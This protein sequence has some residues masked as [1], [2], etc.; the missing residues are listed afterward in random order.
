[1]EPEIIIS[2]LKDLLPK[3]NRDHGGSLISHYINSI[4]QSLESIE[5]NSTHNFF[6]SIYHV[7][8]I[9]ILNEYS[10]IDLMLLF[11]IQT[12]TSDQLP[13]HLRSEYFQHSKYFSFSHLFSEIKL[14]DE[15]YSETNLNDRPA[16][17]CLSN[18]I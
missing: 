14:L 11:L 15:F 12:K 5:N 8:S 4:H 9:R 10:E 18:I 7:E 1:M 17:R 3:K 2:D 16:F 6:K 13:S